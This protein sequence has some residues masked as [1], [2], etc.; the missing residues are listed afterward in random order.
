MGRV[1]SQGPHHPQAVFI[2]QLLVRQTHTHQKK[3]KLQMVLISRVSA[4]LLAG[5][6]SI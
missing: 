4:S 1:H 2:C 5:H 3:E 6:L